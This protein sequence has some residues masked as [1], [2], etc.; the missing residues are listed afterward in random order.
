MNE[1]NKMNK[2]GAFADGEATA[3][4]A[5][6]DLSA[7][8]VPEEGAATAIRKPRK[9]HVVWPW[10]VLA[11]F[12]VA[13]GAAAGGGYWFFQSHALPGVT[14]WGNDVTGR[15]HEQLVAEIDDTVNNTAVPVSYDGKTAKVTL[16]D[17]GLS[18]DSSALADEVMNA[19]R[20]N[21]W[22]Q[23]YAWW[24]NGN[25]S[26]EPANPQAASS[27][28]LSAKLGVEETEPVNASVTL[29]D[30]RSG[31]TVVAGQQGQGVDAEPVAKAA[32]AV[33]KSLG[34]T[35]AQAVEVTTQS[36]DPVVTDAIADKAKTT[37]D[38][39]VKTPVAI[40]IGD[41]EIG[42]FDAA[43]LADATTVDANENAKLADG[44]TRNGYVVFD[45]AKLQQYYDDT[46]KTSLQSKREDREVIVNNSGEEVNVIKEGHDGVTVTAGSDTNV[47]KDAAEALANGGGSV[48]VEGTVDKMQTKKTKRHVVVDL[49][50][51]KVY[52]YE[53]GKLI[54]T[55]N[56]VAAQGNDVKTGACDGTMCTP[57]GDF[58]IWLKYESQD[59][60]GN[61]TLSNG[62]VE[63]WDV[64]DVGYVNYFSHGGCA[65]HRV[66]SST[67]YNDADLVNWPNTSHG[68]VGIGWDVA[69]WFFD[70]C[71]MGTSVHVQQ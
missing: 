61:L 11:V 15:S 2:G 18:V 55:M 10:V 28:A 14:L 68:C 4:F 62:K 69:P 9:R 67:P 64:K 39:L 21:V 3:V 57:T 48:A 19:K 38:G 51:R 6:L 33:V 53:N 7:F 59:M 50:D 27:S 32:V 58:D 8:A 25:V 26:T 24:I 47:G 56:M 29:S 5:P 49:S 44:Q 13:L 66:A 35:S 22:W 31:F 1:N 37:L 70:W 63:K 23:R 30:D 46:I 20:D 45:A 43:A 60:S 36:I 16:K 17:L 42:S 34:S 12:V 54:K 41:R 40:T 52:A 65:I 71:V